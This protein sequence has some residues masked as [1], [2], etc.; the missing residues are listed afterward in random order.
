M[1]VV[2][3]RKLLVLGADAPLRLRLYAL[4]EPRDQFVARFD[5]R[6]VDNV[7]GHLRIFRKG[8]DLTHEA[9]ARAMRRVVGI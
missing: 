1:R 4:G 3:E 5:G 8:R 9:R 2:R 6:Q 7:T